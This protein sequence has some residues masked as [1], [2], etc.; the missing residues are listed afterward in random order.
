MLPL[1]CSVMPIPST[2]HI[3]IQDEDGTL[4]VSLD[5]NFRLCRRKK[6]GRTSVYDQPLT[7]DKV[8]CNQSDVDHFVKSSSR[9]GL[10]EHAG[11]KTEVDLYY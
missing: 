4:F 10:E 9:V 8:F 6:A 7:V 3:I 2:S 11:S 1:I 5:G